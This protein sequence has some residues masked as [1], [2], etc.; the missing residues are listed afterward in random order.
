MKFYLLFFGSF[1]AMQTFAQ[2]SIYIDTRDNKTY[3]LLHFDSITW[4]A[5]NLR[6][7]TKTS[8]C[9]EEDHHDNC[10]LGNYYFHHELD[11]VCPVGWRVATWNDWEG[12]LLGI[13][14][15]LNSN[16]DSIKK[17][18]A[19]WGTITTSGIVL[20]NDSLGMKMKHTGWVQG[21]K[22]S[23]K[24]GAAYWVVDTITND[25]TTHI[26]VGP[27]FYLKHAHDDMIIDKPKKIRRF[28]VRCV[29]I[30]P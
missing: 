16:L 3:E 10:K 27:D 24:K 2:D 13:A 26:H 28:S 6:Y 23:Q 21:K 17:D 18:T 7:D 4:F 12:S 5:S 11:S 9:L 30:N 1:L 8:W 20:L 14:K 25:P 22:K 19:A 15:A 29:K